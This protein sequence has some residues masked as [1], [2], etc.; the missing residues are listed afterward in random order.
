MLPS[1]SMAD[2]RFK[3]RVFVKGADATAPAREERA[4]GFTLSAPHVDEAARR[5]R[6]RLGEQGIRV[7]SL[8][9]A[10][11]NELVVTVTRE[12]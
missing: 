4:L 1:A 10:P 8:S 11:D 9:H 3:A 7:L 6:K 2:R 12:A 5:A